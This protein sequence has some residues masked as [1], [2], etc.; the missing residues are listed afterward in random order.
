MRSAPWALPLPCLA[1]AALHGCCSAAASALCLLWLICL[2]PQGTHTTVTMHGALSLLYTFLLSRLLTPAVSA[3]AIPLRATVAVGSRVSCGGSGVGG[4]GGGGCTK[5]TFAPAGSAATVQGDGT[6]V[7]D[8]PG[9]YLLTAAGAGAG[10]VVAGNRSSQQ[11]GAGG[12]AGRWRAINLPEPM[13]Q[14][15]PLRFADGFARPPGSATAAFN[16]DSV[17]GAWE[18]VD[19]ASQCVRHDPQRG[20]HLVGPRRSSC[21]GVRTTGAVMLP[22]MFAEPLSLTLVGLR[23]SDSLH[24]GPAQAAIIVGFGELTVHIHVGAN[25]RS[26]GRGGATVATAIVMATKGGTAITNASSPLCV[27]GLSLTL[28]ANSANCTVALSCGDPP[29]VVTSSPWNGDGISHRVHCQ[30]R[31]D[32]G[33]Y[34]CGKATLSLSSSG[35]VS[36]RGLALRSNLLPGND[37]LRPT[38]AVP[39]YPAVLAGITDEVG[40]HSADLGEAQ[41]RSQEGIIDV[42]APPFYADATGKRDST[43]AIQAAVDYSREHYSVLFFPEGNYVV[44]DTI[45]LRAI[46]RTMATGHVPGPF[47]SRGHSDDFLLDGVSSRYVPN[48]IVGSKHGSGA[49]IILKKS[50]AG[51]GNISQPKYVLDFFFENSGATPEPNAQYNSMATNINIVISGG[52]DDGGNQGAVGVRLRGAQG[53]GLEDVTVDVGPG[54]AGVVGGCG[55]GGAHHGLHIIGGAYGLD[56]RESQP[57]A[58]ISG[59]TLEG[60]RCGAIV[61]AGFES[62]SAVGVKI[63]NFLGCQAV[64]AI[65][66]A[67]HPF[68]IPSAPK[69]KCTLPLMPTG[70]GFPGDYQ[71]DNPGIAGKMSFIDSSVTWSRDG[72]S[73]P[74]GGVTEHGVTENGTRAFTSMR[75]LFLQNV[76]TSGADAVYA[77][78]GH[79]M[80]QAG[81][82]PPAAARTADGRC[83]GTHVHRALVG[84][85]PPPYPASEGSFQLRAP[86]YID[87][88]RQPTATLYSASPFPWGSN[89]RPNRSFVPAD[90]VSKHRWPAGWDSP[91]FESEDCVNV[92]KLPQNPAQGDGATDDYKAIQDALDKN[93]CVYLPR[94]LY[95]T[96]RTLQVHS[97]RAM[98]G[99]ARH[100][101]RI[102][103]MDTGLV[104][105]PRHRNFLRP[106]DS[107]DRTEQL[108]PQPVVEMLPSA[109]NT[110]TAKAVTHSGSTFLSF[111]SISVWNT[112]NTTSALHW[113]ADNGIYRQLHANRANRCGSLYRPGCNDSVTINYP[114]QLVAG[115]TNLRMY[116]FYL[117]D[118]CHNHVTSVSKARPGVPPYWSG[119]LAGPQGP[120]CE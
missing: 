87:G 120:H 38:V 71:Q 59:I 67:A 73:Y 63:D 15:S 62:L 12:V 22:S 107:G 77:V 117:E 102:T 75:S 36:V 43:K 20:L 76:Y 108:Q 5:L 19:A 34:D 37:P 61:Y 110:S 54:L 42:S 21:A 65:D 86:L 81:C 74:C 118:C 44:S 111:L 53:S 39:V 31:F 96:S 29:D 113:Y 18:R 79:V 46:P 1:G 70:P 14:S 17:V 52:G 27:T 13:G 55:S 9:D 30:D 23:L 90:L 72:P 119:F 56:L 45:V 48:Y 88:V 11:E 92:R 24:P 106:M 85:D 103:S 49:T 47:A 78:A 51:F 41:N 33:E 97:G 100:L 116:T 28:N 99:V 82:L 91:S 7:A 98:V 112:L 58:T 115:A 109:V 35:D 60:Q 94:G 4:G 80:E 8:R 84:V 50:S 10:E 68:D 114:L 57:T 69:G 2:L 95:L 6:F 3:P 93:H 66:S 89:G 83:P 25:D 101:T 64:T 104:G 32:D 40:F 26:S 16:S 105:P